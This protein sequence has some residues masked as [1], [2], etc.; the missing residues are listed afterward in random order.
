MKELVKKIL[1]HE[2]VVSIVAQGEDFP[3]MVNTWNS[4]L[5]YR[6]DLFFLPVGGMNTME[7]FL[8]KDNR[9]IVSFGSIEVD[10]LNGVGSGAGC[11][12][13][14]KAQIRDDILEYKDIKSKFEWARAVM[15]IDIDNIK[16]TT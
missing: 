13:E 2:G 12:V 11:I 6:D 14:G 5:V 7:G 9:V 4:S 16:Q 1:E 8:K 15:K 10:G 3:Y